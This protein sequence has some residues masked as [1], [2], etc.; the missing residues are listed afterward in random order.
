MYWGDGANDAILNLR[1]NQ[2]AISTEGFQIWYDNNVGDVHLH[3]T[4]TS[5]DAAIRFIHEQEQ[6]VLQIMK[7]LLF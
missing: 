1:S 4:Y 7:D 6:I 5:A 3:T 2:G